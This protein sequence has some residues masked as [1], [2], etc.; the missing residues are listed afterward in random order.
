MH[1]PYR[2]IFLFYLIATLQVGSLFAAERGD[3]AITS[4]MGEEGE[5]LDD[6]QKNT[7][8]L[9]SCKGDIKA[10]LFPTGVT[11]EYP[12]YKEELL[13]AAATYFPANRSGNL[14]TAYVEFGLGGKATL[15]FERID[16]FTYKKERT[17]QMGNA[18]WEDVVLHQE[19]ALHDGGFDEWL[20]ENEITWDR[21]LVL[22]FI[23]VDA[24]YKA[25]SLQRKYASHPIQ[26]MKNFFSALLVSFLGVQLFQTKRSK[27]EEKG[28]FSEEDI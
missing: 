19:L 17:Y 13:A 4:K 22:P 9:G 7:L 2:F 3:D 24:L 23:I 8:M 5:G 26:R 15:S 16:F 21:E 14:F 18:S 11:A 6:E 20:N 12:S 1:Q 25:D 27:A 10:F 28:T